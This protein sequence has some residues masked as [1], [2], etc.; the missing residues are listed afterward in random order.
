MTSFPCPT[1]SLLLQ[2]FGRQ[3][4]ARMSHRW[5]CSSQASMS[6]R[7][8]SATHARSN[9]LPKTHIQI[10][11]VGEPPQA[12]GHKCDWALSVH[13]NL[14][15]N[16]LSF[17]KK[18]KRHCQLLCVAH[19]SVEWIAAE[20]NLH[21]RWKLT[22]VTAETHIQTPERSRA[23]IFSSCIERSVHASAQVAMQYSKYHRSDCFH[24]IY[25]K[26]A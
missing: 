15:P 5:A 10:D 1:L 3:Q 13:A 25:E 7:S 9:T 23:S 20:T 17:A 24:L 21:H 4:R 14:V 22:P 8:W 12:K 2:P 18:K 19:V 26:P 16:Q 11:P 6:R